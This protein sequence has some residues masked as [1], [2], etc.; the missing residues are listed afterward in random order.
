MRVPHRWTPSGRFCATT[1]V[2][3]TLLA[4]SEAPE[5]QHVVRA[6]TP[7]DAARATPSPRADVVAA[8]PPSA[9]RSTLSPPAQ[10]APPGLALVGTT[11]GDLQGGIEEAERFLGFKV[12]RSD[13][14]ER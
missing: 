13:D 5:P 11:V 8:T 6:S 14:T 4:C 2:L 1:A 3:L 12:T 10:A 9:A 7:I